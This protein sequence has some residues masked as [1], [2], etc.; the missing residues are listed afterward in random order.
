MNVSQPALDGAK[1]PVSHNAIAL[2]SI[3]PR[4]SLPTLSQTTVS[5]RLIRIRSASNPASVIETCSPDGGGGELVEVELD[6]E[7]EEA[8]ELDDVADEEELELD[9]DELALELVEVPEGDC[10]GV[11]VGD[12]EVVGVGVVVAQAGG[13]W[14]GGG[15]SG[16]QLGSMSIAASGAG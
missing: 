9:E 6:V 7:V 11:P 2:S 3:A 10:V 4:G 14:P 12:G 16:C 1:S 5:P 13:T 15:W 8:V